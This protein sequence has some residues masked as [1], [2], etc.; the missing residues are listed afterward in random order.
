MRVVSLNVRHGGGT[1]I[2]AIVEWV[3]ACAPDIAVFPEWRANKSSAALK[4][5][6]EELGFKTDSAVRSLP[7]SNGLMIAAKERFSGERLTPLDAEKGE[8]LLARWSSGLV[9]VAAYF[10]QLHAKRPFFEKCM[11]VTREHTDVPFL[12]IGDINTGR[13]DLDV[14]ANGTRFYCEDQFLVLEAQAGL[15]DLWRAEHGDCKE[16][17]WRSRANGFRVDH[18]FGNRQ[19]VKQL[20]PISIRYDHQPREKATTDHSGLILDLGRSTH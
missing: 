6:L 18:A 11:T 7:R 5:A 2:S 17:T 10:P 16:W 1:R 20:A 9:I 13:N 3:R 12:L 4:E 15:R 8:L 14:E 19:L